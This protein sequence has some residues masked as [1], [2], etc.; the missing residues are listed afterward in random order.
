MKGQ[1][2]LLDERC[3]FSRNDAGAI[4][5]QKTKKKKKN[6]K[7]YMSHVIQKVIKNVLQ[8][9]SCAGGLGSILGQ[10][11]RSHMPQ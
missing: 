8:G 3:S 11:T 9:F 4:G 1:K 6:T 2:Q 5:P 7:T 10:G